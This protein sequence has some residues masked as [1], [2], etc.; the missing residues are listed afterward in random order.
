VI[1]PRTDVEEA[2]RPNFALLGKWC[3]SHP[4]ACRKGPGAPHPPHHG[5]AARVGVRTHRV[6]HG[7]AK[8][9]LQNQG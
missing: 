6:Q 8:T 3:H 7:I 4:V 1:T 5:A 9:P 2:L